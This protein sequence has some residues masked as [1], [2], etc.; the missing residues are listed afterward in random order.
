M[1]REEYESRLREHL[2]AC[3]S[4][5]PIPPRSGLSDLAEQQCQ[6]LGGHLINWLNDRAPSLLSERAVIARLQD[7]ETDPLIC[8]V[9]DIPGLVAADE[10]LEGEHERIVWGLPEDFEPLIELDQEQIFHVRFCSHFTAV[11]GADLPAELHEKHDIVADGEY[12]SHRDESVMGP[13]FVRGCLHLWRWD[14]A[15]EDASGS[16]AGAAFSRPRRSL[17][18]DYFTF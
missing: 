18:I 14:G 3:R 1:H 5:N 16:A 15:S 8:V 9:S 10:I 12:F 17:W 13:L 2:V 6:L 4:T 7:W 11:D